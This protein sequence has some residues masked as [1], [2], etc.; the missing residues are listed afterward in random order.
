AG[1]RGVAVALADRRT[2]PVDGWL[3]QVEVLGGLFPRLEAIPFLTNG[4]AGDVGFSFHLDLM[5]VVDRNGQH[6]LLSG[7]LDRLE[8]ALAVPLTN[9]LTFSATKTLGCKPRR[10]RA[11]SK[12]RSS[13]RCWVSE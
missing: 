5:I 1:C 7:L 8:A 6:R 10:R 4:V 2:G 13:V 11:N 12:K 3:D 9:P